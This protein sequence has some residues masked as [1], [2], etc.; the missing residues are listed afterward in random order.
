MNLDLKFWL[1]FSIINLTIVA[2]LGLLMRYKIGFEFPYLDQRNLLHSHSHFAFAGWVSHTLIVLMVYFLK[3]KINNL[4]TVI[5]KNI[6]ISN[7][8]CSYG[9]LL[10]FAMQGYSAYSI[11]FSTVSI[12]VSFVFGYYYFKDLK[13]INSD[14]LAINWFKAAIVFNIISCIGT[15]YLAYMMISKN[16][17]QDFYLASIYYYLHFQYNGWFFFGCMGLL[18]GYL[19][20]KKTDYPYFNN[21]LK[22]FAISC[23]PAYF[24]ST[25]WL[26]LPLWLYSITVIVAFIQSIAWFKFLYYLKQSKISFLEN[27]SKLFKNILR[28]VAF[29]VSVKI[30]LQLGSTIPA[31]NQLAFGFRP[32]VIAYLHLILLAIITLFLLSYIIINPFFESSRKINFG[33]IIFTIGVVFNEIILGIQGIAAF[34][35][36]MIPKVNEM[37]LVAAIFLFIG[38]AYTSLQIIKNKTSL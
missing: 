6:I 14:Y 23:I 3:T 28:F 13:Q 35:Y 20:L 29:A 1:K 9:M 30:L 26:D 19:N 10:F 8:I 36:T 34:S 16:I 4:K 22:L 18:F 27:Q 24:L 38:I 17:V 2:F 25:L 15:F 37:L 7:L 33:I 21:T 5:Y 31:L 12:L 11:F 32:I